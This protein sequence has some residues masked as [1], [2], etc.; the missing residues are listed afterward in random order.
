MVRSGA[1][2]R[3]E[4]ALALAGGL[5]AS[6]MRAG[7]ARQDDPV[8][9]YKRSIVI[10]ALANPQSFNVPWPPQYRGLTEEQISSARASGITAINVTVNEGAADFSGF[11]TVVSHIAF[12]MS[13]VQRNPQIFSLILRGADIAAAK[14]SHRVGL[15]LGFQGTDVLGTDL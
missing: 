3:R 11:E 12:W 15:M 4:F 9:I 1:L 8:A 2:N 6:G 13:E 5:V 14:Q 10:D 7:D